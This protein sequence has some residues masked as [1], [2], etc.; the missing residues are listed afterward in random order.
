MTN[1]SLMWFRYDLR[2]D[3]NAALFEACENQICLPIFI[4]DDGYLKLKL[5]V[6]FI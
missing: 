2:V 4:L 5:L 6:T 3:D 1:N